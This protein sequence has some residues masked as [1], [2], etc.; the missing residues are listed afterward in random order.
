MTRE[1]F[2]PFLA[3]WPDHPTTPT[4]GDARAVLSAEMA[5]AA[6]ATAEGRIIE[7]G[8]QLLVSKFSNHTLHF[9]GP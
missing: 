1:R 8:A 3:T 7:G 6:A 9:S 5:N 2:S 4:V